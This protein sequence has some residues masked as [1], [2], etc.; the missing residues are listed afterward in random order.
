M[1][2][3]CGRFDNNEISHICMQLFSVSQRQATVKR[4][5]MPA[6]CTVSYS[7]P[8]FSTAVPG[9][10]CILSQLVTVDSYVDA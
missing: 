6:V 1:Y 8:T 5:S 4:E 3:W 10:R 7:D 2:D 9:S